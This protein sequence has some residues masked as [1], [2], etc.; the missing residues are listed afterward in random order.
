MQMVC[1]LIFN[2]ISNINIV[3]PMPLLHYQKNSKALDTGKIV[4]GIFIDFRKTFN[5]IPH[6]TLVKKYLFL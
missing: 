5:V 6:K 2:W 1:Y 4:C 3:P